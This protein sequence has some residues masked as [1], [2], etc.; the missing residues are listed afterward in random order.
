MARGSQL[1]NVILDA[2]LAYQ[3]GDPYFVAGQSVLPG[4]RASRRQADRGLA[5]LIAAVEREG[6]RKVKVESVGAAAEVLFERDESRHLAQASAGCL[7]TTLTLAVT[8]A[9]AFVAVVTAIVV[10]IG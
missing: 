1:D 7:M 9:T 8:M 6:W 10:A 3:G 2:R 4:M 5:E